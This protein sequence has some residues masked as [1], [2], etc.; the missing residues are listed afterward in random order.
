MARPTDRVPPPRRPWVFAVED[1]TV[2]LSWIAGLFRPGELR[3]RAAGRERTVRTD[4][5]PGTVVLED[6]PPASALTLVLDGDAAAG[7][8]WRV[9]VRTLAP[10]PGEELYRFATVS[11]L[12]LGATT[13]GYRGTMAERPPPAEPHPVRAARAAL[14]EATAWGAQLMVVKGDLTNRGQSDEWASVGSLLRDVTVPVEML[15][16][17]HDVRARAGRVDPYAALRELGHGLAAHVETVDVPGLRLVLADTTVWGHDHGRIADLAAAV[18]GAARSAPGPTFV[19]TH[20]Y[21]MRL[22]VATFWPPGIPSYEANPFLRWLAAANPASVVSSGHTH[23]HRRRRVGPLLLTEV[24]S[25]KDYPGTWAGYAVH[26]GGIRQVVRRVAAPDV[27]GW[28]DVSA[29]AAWHLWSKWSPGLLSHRCFTHVWPPRRPT[30]L[31]WW[32]VA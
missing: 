32:D 26:E 2:Q 8:R 24:G 21:A 19:A 30:P 13:F 3:I 10:P 20:H 6:L 12:H 25:P 22:P 14:A 9:P 18:V 31:R 1:T 7:R 16:G 5:G 17:N 23:R 4:G 27:L 11:D 15:P 28:L 29:D